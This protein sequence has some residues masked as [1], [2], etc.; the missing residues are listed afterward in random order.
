MLGQNMLRLYTFS[1]SSASYRVRI[2]LALK[3]LSYE[4]VGISLTANAH[5]NPDYVSLNPQG[6]V[7][8]LATD[9]G[10]LT[11]SLAIL[12]WLEETQNGPSL[13]PQDAWTRAQCRAFAHVIAT[14]IFPLQN[15]GARQKLEA[16]FGADAARQAVWSADWIA[17]G[18]AALEASLF[19]QNRPLAGEYL[20]AGY[21]TLA[22]ICLV[23]QMNNARRYQVDL[24]PFPILVAADAKARAH[25]AFVS[26][27]PETQAA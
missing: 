25:P 17:K 6:R 4:A 15:L 14:D 3:G 20:F 18:F 1:H 16:E 12:D 24:S 13:Y 21:P 26:T 19:Q 10:L 22:D 9:E 7:P 5:K 27:A 2:A 8:A 11:Q 23:A